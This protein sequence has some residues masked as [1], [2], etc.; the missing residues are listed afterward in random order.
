MSYNIAFE[1][2]KEIIL[3]N[4]R[5]IVKVSSHKL[6]LFFFFFFT[7]IHESYKMNIFLRVSKICF[8]NYIFLCL[9]LT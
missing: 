1:I 7:L 3:L 8:K 4:T 6:V 5:L 2:N 9:P